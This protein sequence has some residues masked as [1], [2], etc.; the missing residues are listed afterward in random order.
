MILWCWLSWLLQ[1]ATGP[2]NKLAKRLIFPNGIHTNVITQGH[3]TERCYDKRGL[4]DLAPRLTWKPMR[5]DS[6]D[7]WSYST[8]LETHK[9]YSP[10]HWLWLTVSLRSHSF[11]RDLREISC[12]SRA[13]WADPLH[14]QPC[15][16]PLFIRC[17]GTPRQA[18]STLS[19]YM[20]PLNFVY[21]GHDHFLIPSS[22]SGWSFNSK[23]HLM[24]LICI[25]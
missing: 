23:F 6:F 20:V 24:G 25:V 21:L 13:A 11:S 16:D 10:P 12:G 17:M 18:P 22:P 4:E 15:T 5:V 14:S 19:S 7:P 3:Q 2:K 9:I 1:L 8:S